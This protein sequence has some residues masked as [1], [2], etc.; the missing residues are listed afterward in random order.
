M[1]YRHYGGLEVA[2]RE[3]QHCPRA[4]N[5]ELTKQKNRR[6]QTDDEQSRLATRDECRRRR[7]L[8]PDKRCRGEKHHDRDGDNNKCM[9]TLQPSSRHGR[10]ED[11]VFPR[12]VEFHVSLG[13]H[14]LR[15]SRP[16]KS[17]R[18]I[19]LDPPGGRSD[20]H[21]LQRR[22]YIADTGLQYYRTFGRKAGFRSPIPASRVTPWVRAS[23]AT[24]RLESAA[25]QVRREPLPTHDFKL[26]VHVAAR[27]VGIGAY[28]VVGFLGERR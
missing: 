23:A 27:R 25:A 11:L 9:P 20:E 22:I 15:A 4:Q 26:H 19:A 13:C 18:R 16:E 5:R 21:T 24:G 14:G 12:R 2:G 1:R 10:Q 6:D 17:R 7:K 3:H 28:L 8:H